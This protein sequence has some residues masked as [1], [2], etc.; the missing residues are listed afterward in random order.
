MT[1]IDRFD[2]R[3]GRAI[4]RF[5]DEATPIDPVTMA[6][7]AMGRARRRPWT[8]MLGERPPVAV[9]WLVVGAVVSAV[10]GALVLG[11]GKPPPIEVVPS[12]TRP[13][14]HPDIPAELIGTWHATIRGIT[15]RWDTVDFHGEFL[16]LDIYGEPHADLG[17]VVSVEPM[18]STSVALLIDGP[19]ACAEAQYIVRFLDP[20]QAWFVPQKEPC[21]ERGEILH[22]G[23]PWVLGPPRPQLPTGEPARAASFGEPFDFV[24]YQLDP[25]WGAVRLVDV[26]AP[27]RFTIRTDPSGWEMNFFD[28]WP[29][30]EHLCG[31]AG[32]M[33][34][35][36]ATLS[37][38]ATWLSDSGALA[39]KPILLDVD[40]RQAMRFDL[41]WEAC[42]DGRPPYAAV[43]H[44]SV[45]LFPVFRIYAIET[46]DDIVIVQV[47]ADA[48][49]RPHAMR[50]ADKLITS[51]D[52]D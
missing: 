28:D 13:A 50:N 43:L 42:Q 41:N 15:N 40:G 23:N 14:L 26:D 48:G 16:L 27:A 25:T 17:K 22:R 38:V 34:D 33:P 21:D 19:E 30:R 12:P 36:P 46:G 45:L 35:A 7:R 4:E 3:L 6:T 18:D 29:M 8:R 44:S 24:A 1:D 39:A 20:G 52:F 37:D 49:S 10:A 5:A 47:W 32:A 11:A 2:Q 9:R 31:D 51:M